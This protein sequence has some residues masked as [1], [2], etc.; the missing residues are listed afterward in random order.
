MVPHKAKSMTALDLLCKQVNQVEKSY[1][2]IKGKFDH[3]GLDMD[4]YML[5]GQED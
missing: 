3:N 1:S 5:C 4:I 2:I